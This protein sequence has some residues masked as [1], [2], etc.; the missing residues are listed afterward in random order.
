MDSGY[1][2]LRAESS[3]EITE[4][5]SR[6]IAVLAHAE[7]LDEAM[8][9]VTR[10]R[11][12]HYNATHNVYAILLRDGFQKY[13]DDGEPSRTAGYPV[14]ELL[15]A[16][17]I[18]DCVCVVTRYFGGTLLGTGGLIRAYSR[19]AK[20][21]LSRAPLYKNVLCDQVRVTTPY[22]FL[23]KLEHILKTENYPVLDTVYAQ[24]AAVT[25]LSE[26]PRTPRLYAA[27]EEAFGNAVRIETI[28]TAYHEQTDDP[29]S[30]KGV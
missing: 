18:T 12:Q 19:A 11:K 5:K 25:I 9:F 20:E 2:T 3:A 14:L 24:D 30:R 26:C 28:H 21:A 13:S 16:E 6:F 27:V 1:I 15:S 22:T 23:S 29:N 8:D 17:G 10:I 4:K 7:T